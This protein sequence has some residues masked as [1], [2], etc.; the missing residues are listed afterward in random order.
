M[1]ERRWFHLTGQMAEEIS[2]GMVSQICERRDFHMKNKGVITCLILIVTLVPSI[3]F[4]AIELK[5][6]N[7]FP[8]PARQSKICE[9][10]IKDLE[11]RSGGELKIRLFTAGTLLSPA[12]IYDGVVEGIADIGFSNIGYTFGRFRM[13][14]ALDLPLGFPNAWVANHVAN[15][16]YR[17][18]KPKEWDKIH[19]LSMHTSPVNVVLSATKP[20]YKMDDLKGMTLRGTGLIAEVVSAL[21]G[22]PRSIA[23][24]EAYEALQKK[25][26]G[27][28]MIPMET[29]RAFRLAEV[30][31]YATECWP[32]GQVYTFYLVMNKDTW[33]KLPPNIQKIFNEYPFEEKF[34]TMWNE[35]DI[36]G[37]KFGMEKGLKFIELSPDEM[38]KWKNAV[39]PVIDKY[40]KSMTDAGYPTKEVRES[41]NYI[42]MRI[43]YWT[44]RQKELGI[45]SSTGPAAVRVQ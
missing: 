39:E 34:A 14:E 29:L 31:K 10:F 5:F 12:K 26:I 24:P 7:Y 25:V 4:G 38:K 44:K 18:F 3:V 40:V 15:D 1:G 35:I 6:A 16:F 13:T 43:E 21:G 8:V 36:D 11:A 22:T 19:M 45:K 17:Q 20:V 30:T 41:I 27:G 9:E 33:N 42:R 32:I 28:L 37:K 23:M 2:G